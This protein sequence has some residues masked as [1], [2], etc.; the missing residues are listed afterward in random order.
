MFSNKLHLKY[1]FFLYNGVKNENVSCLEVIKFA[2]PKIG[3]R[4][5]K[6]PNRAIRR[7]M[8]ALRAV[9]FVYY[10]IDIKCIYNF[11]YTK[12]LNLL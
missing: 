12:R 4:K 9:I 3:N 10:Y 11:N 7:M 5:F 1:I 8:P 6:F 2:V